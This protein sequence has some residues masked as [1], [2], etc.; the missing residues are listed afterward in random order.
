MRKPNILLIMTDQ[1]SAAAIGAGGNPVVNTPNIDRLASEG[2]LFSNCY[3]PSP[4]CGPARWS[5]MTGLYAHNHK[6]WDNGNALSSETPTFAHVLTLA[7]Y[8]TVIASRMHFNGVDQ[9]HGYEKRLATEHNNPIDYGAEPLW[10]DKPVTP[11]YAGSGPREYQGTF[12]VN[13]S[14]RTAHD[15]W[16]LE[17]NIEYLKSRQW[18]SRPF[19]LTASFLSP[20]PSV[21]RR[22]EYLEIFHEYLGMDLGARELNREDFNSLHPHTKRMISKGKQ[23]AFAQSKE[24]NHH[25]RAE[26]YS[27]VT[28]FDRQVG[29]LLE[30]LEDE[31]LRDE[32]LIVLTS[33][34]GDDMG[35]FGYWGKTS[36]YDNV[37]KVPLIISTPQTIRER[38]GA[39]REENVSLIDLFPTFAE[40]AD[41]APLEYEIDGHS[42]VPLLNGDSVAWNNCVFS[43]YYGQYAKKAM[44]MLKKD[45]LKYNFYLDDP[46][47]LFDLDN[48]PG[49]LKNLI[50][51]DQYATEIKKMAREL[52]EICDPEALW[53][54]YVQSNLRR[55]LISLTTTASI[56]TK[57][58]I[59]DYIKQYR[60]EWNEPTWDDNK[61]LFRYES[62]LWE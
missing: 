38:A 48:D 2:T 58:R 44:F 59:R 62:H 49:E 16:V 4:I 7:G 21:K 27:R 20:H 34:H 54:E 45:A 28:Y 37:A 47:E 56:Q 1:L 43:E 3:T 53:R 19:M 36:F 26:Y 32:T 17:K 31:G 18:G 35:R 15:D 9:Y 6:G 25:F 23:Q 41:A 52:R 46:A 61:E 30:V 13:D 11:E 22:G 10:R 57:Q 12:P 39:I 42:L 55:K 8:E 60:L 29:D 40:F 50:E 14:P 33:D 24:E 51:N 5:L